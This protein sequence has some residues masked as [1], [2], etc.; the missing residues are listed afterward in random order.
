MRRRKKCA[1]REAGRG[2]SHFR[3]GRFRVLARLA[4]M[5]ASSFAGSSGATGGSS[6]AMPR[7]RMER[8]DATSLCSR[9]LSL[10]VASSASATIACSLRSRCRAELSSS[11]RFS[12]PV[13]M[14]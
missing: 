12:M 1:R 9:A 7:R 8:S 13:R 14:T 3:S 5:I 4:L 11:T 10:C 6:S 2:A